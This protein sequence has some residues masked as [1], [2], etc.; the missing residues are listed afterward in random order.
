M[1]NIL[2][3]GA[4]RGIGLELT[5]QY[6]AAGWD[7]I[8]TCR[9]PAT[10]TDLGTLG[11][12]E[13]EVRELDVTDHAAI[14]TLAASL[15]GA[16]LDVLLN[17]AG[18]IGPVPV[19]EH[20][21][22]QHFGH[23]DYELWTRVLR[24]NTFGPI[25]LAE[26]LLPNILAGQQKKIVTLSSTVGS[27]VERDTPAFAYATSKTAVNKAMRLLA[28]QLRPQ[29]VIVALLCPGY[30]K[31]RLDFGTADVEPHDSVAGMRALIDGFTLD[32]SGTFRRYNGDV[33][34]W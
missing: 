19:A 11:C 22:R 33:I 20:I 26:A 12:A 6:L 15:G 21:E 10:A 3:T 1:P 32:D 14:D 4:N 17:N 24:T 8:A 9:D 30:V 13:L 5:R 34:A 25:K 23:L 2:I 18:I 27:I 29:G 7:V 28:V 16:P 31:T